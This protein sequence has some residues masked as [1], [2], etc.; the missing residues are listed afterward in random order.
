MGEPLYL[1]KQGGLYPIKRGRLT[2]KGPDFSLTLRWFIRYTSRRR[3][4][5]PGQT[6]YSPRLGHLI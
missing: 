6:H 1:I 4:L 3:R 2:G 5:A